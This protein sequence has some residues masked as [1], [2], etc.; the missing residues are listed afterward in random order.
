[1]IPQGYRLYITN[2]EIIGLIL[3]WV[4]QERDGLTI[5]RPVC[6]T[7]GEG[8]ARGGEPWVPEADELFMV[9]DRLKDARGWIGVNLHA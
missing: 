5:F 8:P 2:G 9:T 3:G 1:M 7:L 4:T 6:H